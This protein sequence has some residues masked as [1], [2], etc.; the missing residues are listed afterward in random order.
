MYMTIPSGS[1]STVWT[2]VL[3]TNGFLQNI[4]STVT[5]YFRIVNWGATGTAGTWYIYD[6]FPSSDAPV[7]GTNDFVISGGLSA[8]LGFFPSGSPTNV[9]LTPSNSITA[10]AGATV[11]FSVSAGGNPASNFWYQIVG[12]ATNLIAGPASSTL[13]LT[14]V[15][16]TNAG[17]YFVV[18][19][20]S[21]GVATSLL[22]L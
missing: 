14:N 10:N 12:S 20:N 6:P 11:N 18:L 17:D 1:S 9:V 3:S 8:L 22:C 7:L 4:P 19:T 21:Y 16:E 15:L 2:N 5:N 13:T